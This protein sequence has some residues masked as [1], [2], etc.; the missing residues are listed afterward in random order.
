MSF[1]TFTLTKSYFWASKHEYHS[2]LAKTQRINGQIVAHETK[3]GM[4]LSYPSLIDLRTMN[5]GWR[6]YAVLLCRR[7]Q[8][9]IIM[10]KCAR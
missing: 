4:T 9:A 5:Q 8:N 10:L 7:R 3:M 1:E 2:N 6:L